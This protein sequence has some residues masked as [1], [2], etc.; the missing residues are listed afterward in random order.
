MGVMSLE[1]GRHIIIAVKPKFANGHVEQAAGCLSIGRHVQKLK[2]ALHAAMAGREL[3]VRGV[4]EALARRK[5]WLLSYHTG[6]SEFFAMTILM[7]SDPMPIFQGGCLLALVCDLYL[8][9]PDK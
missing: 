8:V 2:R 3:A 1:A 6:A 5:V 9:G 7:Q 4:G